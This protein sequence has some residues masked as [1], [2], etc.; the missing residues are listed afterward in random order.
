MACFSNSGKR[1]VKGKSHEVIV[2]KLVK[3]ISEGEKLNTAK[4]DYEN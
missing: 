4:N 2:D 3:P 1:R